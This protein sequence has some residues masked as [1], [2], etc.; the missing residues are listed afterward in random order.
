MSGH[1]GIGTALLVV[2]KGIGSN[3]DDGHRL[4][5]GPVHQAD[6]TGCLGTAEHGHHLVHQYH[7]V[8]ANRR[9]LEP[10]HGFLAVRGGF[11]LYA[12][13]L[14]HER[15]DLGIELVV[16]CKEGALAL[17]RHASLRR[18]IGTG[19]G[20]G[21][22]LELEFDGEG[23]SLA[24]HAFKLDGSAQLVHDFFADGKAQTRAP[25]HRMRA[26]VF[27]GKRLE[28]ALLEFLAHAD[29]GILAHEAHANTAVAI[30][31]L[32]AVK[33]SRAACAVV[34]EGVAAQV[35]QHL[36]HVQRASH[37]AGMLHFNR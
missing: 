18:G 1:A 29:A 28:G 37:D 14:K 8:V 11:H 2:G 26:G 20:I 30:G 7:V 33:P 34:L 32:L 4:G 3:G 25:V 12:L 35:L 27:L 36:L 10:I 31:N 23:G 15:G 16:F 22:H 5:I 9:A 17:Q 21:I 19:A 24:L 6:G 13:L